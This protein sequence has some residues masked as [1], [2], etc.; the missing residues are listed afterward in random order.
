MYKNRT[1]LDEIKQG[2]SEALEEFKIRN[3]KEKYSKCFEAVIDA[4]CNS[5]NKIYIPKNFAK[6][7]SKTTLSYEGL[8]PRYNYVNNRYYRKE[9]E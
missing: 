6:K 5:D 9:R 4:I 7:V 3:D 2:I 8:R 1:P